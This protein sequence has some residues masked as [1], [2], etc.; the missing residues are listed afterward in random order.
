M[1]S[2]IIVTNSD[3]V[4]ILTL[5]RTFKI[6]ILRLIKDLNDRLD[7]III[8][9]T[10]DITNMV[11]V[12][13]NTNLTEATVQE[14]I[15]RL[16]NGE[17]N[18]LFHSFDISQLLNH[19]MT[20]SVI[21]TKATLICL[22][23]F[24]KKCISCEEDLDVI[25]N[26]YIN[27]Y[28]LDKIIKGGVYY[29]KC[30]RCHQ[31]FYPHYFE[32]F[33]NGKRFV[34]TNC[35][36][37]QEY[38]YFGGKKAYSTQLLINFTSLFLR[39]Y[40]GFENFEN[41]YNLSLKKYHNLNSNKSA[42]H[43]IT[44][45]ISREYFSNI[46]FIYQLSLY[47][48]FMNDLREFE[49]PGLLDNNSIY[50]FFYMNYDQWYN[51]FV[52]HWATHHRTHPCA[53]T[54]TNID[55]GCMKCF[56]LDGMQKVA[57]PICTNKNKQEYTEEFPDGIYVGCGNTPKAKSGLCESCR[58]SILLKDSE[59]SLLTDDDK[60]I[61]DDPLMGCN[62]SREDHFVDLEKRFSQG[63]I[64]TLSPCGIVVGFDEIFRSESCFIALQHL[65]K[66]IHVINS[67]Y[68]Q[69]LPKMIIYDNACSLY[70]YFWNRY[71]KSD[72]NR[73]IPPT[74]SSK[75]ISECS[76]FIDRFHQPNHK[77]PMCQK[78]RNLDYIHTDAAAKSI[79]TEVAEQR[80]SVL[81][82]YHNALSSYSS[83]KAR[84]AY[85]VLFHLMNCERNTCDNQFEYIRK[86][87]A[88]RRYV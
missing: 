39:Q 87:A 34:T 68:H 38:I 2:N 29:S 74:S 40:S 41:S 6:K 37:N 48:F 4:Y 49:I 10:R 21:D 73:H 60:G 13:F 66:I 72:P 65:F 85:L 67:Q 33:T 5:H 62:V 12:K 11:N 53:A 35:L 9:R 77:R 58:Q 36:Y 55:P 63:I 61:Y 14:I 50:D 26:Q 45:E 70:I 47:T 28:N 51:D 52:N 42:V 64:Y 83:K 78:E 24:T 69:Y 23:P 56:V 79:N 7:S 75:F 3:E 81:K 43:E 1:S 80:N 27:I 71:G 16:N 46:W 59:T 84:I 76:F 32:K 20:S 18:E 57:R 15:N 86:Y 88:L 19:Y 17:M 31:K 54:R 22:K 30:N 82:Q 44:S 8:T 25:F